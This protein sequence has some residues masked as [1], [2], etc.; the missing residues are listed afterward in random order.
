MLE[1]HVQSRQVIAKARLINRKFAFAGYRLMFRWTSAI[2]KS[3]DKDLTQLSSTG[4]AKT[5]RLIRLDDT[6]SFA[7][8]RPHH[9]GFPISGKVPSV[10]H[11]TTVMSKFTN[12]TH[13]D[14]RAWANRHL[15]DDILFR[16]FTAIKFPC[17]TH[18]T[19]WAAD[20]EIFERMR[21]C[22]GSETEKSTASNP[23]WEVPQEVKNVF[24]RLKCLVLHADK[25]RTAA[26]PIE[27]KAALF[28]ASLADNVEVL[29]LRNLV[30]DVMP[31]GF[32]LAR[33]RKLRQLSVFQEQLFVSTDGIKEI[34]AGNVKT[35]QIVEV[36]SW[37]T[38]MDQHVALLQWL[39]GFPSLQDVLAL[40]THAHWNHANCGPSTGGLREKA[41]VGLLDHINVNRRR[42]NLPLEESC[43]ERP[44]L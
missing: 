36:T 11:F 5:V 29:H 27:A 14:M 43:Y 44:Q 12:L 6:H 25:R 18:L 19:L 7:S 31:E 35:L 26:K 16:M 23:D 8:L 9:W 42:Q 24:S 1:N 40:A 3:F 2:T 30:F 41:Y 10:E 4:F 15:P 37:Y 17:L 13:L 28:L 34:L 38:P 33:N 22:S 20:C 21:R 32:Q 39:L